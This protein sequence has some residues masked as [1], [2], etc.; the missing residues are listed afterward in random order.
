M[1]SPQNILP[2]SADDDDPV[3]RVIDLGLPKFVDAHT[4]LKTFCSTPRYF[5]PVV[6]LSQ[7]RGDGSYNS[8]CDTWSLGVIL[9]ILL[10]GVPPF[11]SNDAVRQSVDGDDSSLYILLSGVPPFNSNDAVRQIADSDDSS[12]WKEWNR[13]SSKPSTWRRK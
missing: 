4:H 11:N 9:Y 7:V 8:N 12:P 10:S 1:T 3:I 6:L 13:M 2:C 5:A